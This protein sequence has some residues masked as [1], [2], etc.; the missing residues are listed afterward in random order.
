[1]TSRSPVLAWSKQDFV[2]LGIGALALVILL[3]LLPYAAGYA[4][5]RKTIA[6]ILWDRWFDAQS[7]TWQYGVLVAPTVGWLVWK[8]RSDI[9]RI[10]P[11][12]SWLGLPIIIF[13]LACYFVGYK[14]NSYYFGFLA[15][16]CFVLGSVL[17][18]LGWRHLRLL[19]FP[20][21]MLAFAWPMIFLEDRI[22]FPL[23]LWSTKGVMFLAHLIGAPIRSEGTSL[24]S[25]S[26]GQDI[27]SWMTLKVDGPCSGMNTLFAL[28]F[29]GAL[30]SYFSQRRL[31]CR[32]LLFVCSIPLAIAGNMLRIALLIVG[33]ALFGQDFAVGNQGNDM[34]TYHLLA[35]LSVFPVLVIGLQLIS[36]ALHRAL[37][38]RLKT[39]GTNH[40]SDSP[41]TAATP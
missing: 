30:V 19:M 8:R 22:G 3:A 28:M 15:L 2:G 14:A 31:G 27:G 20:W 4:D 35:G 41:A 29:V 38:R 39:A 24:F 12:S 10:K 13:A 26:A 23:R 17:W 37:P 6:C 16:Q 21:L 11:V 18:L 33:C 36:R 25:A 32:V 9:A 40:H 1:M 7:T 5:Y 34:T